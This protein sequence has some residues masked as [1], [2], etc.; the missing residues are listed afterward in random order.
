MDIP[1][2]PL[3]LTVPA[4]W[5]R[6]PVHRY[7]ADVPKDSVKAGRIDDPIWDIPSEVGWRISHRISRGWRLLIAGALGI[8]ILTVSL[9]GV[10]SRSSSHSGGDPNGRILHALEPALTA[11]PVNS[12]N[13]VRQSSD[14]EWSAACPDNPSGQAGWS[15]VRA[16]ASFSTTLPKNEVVREVNGSLVKAGWTRHDESFGPGQGKVA[17]WTKR[18]ASSGTGEAAVYALSAGSTNWLLTLTSKPPGFALPGC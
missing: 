17:H 2:V 6:S 10:V 8:L 3:C 4:L 18:L 13:V 9:I 11:V 7:S 14:S 15:E 16:D 5:D 1:N 12:S